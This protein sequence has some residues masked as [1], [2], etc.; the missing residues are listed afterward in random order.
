M[1]K[2]GQGYG[3]KR[4]RMTDRDRVVVYYDKDEKQT[5]A[6]AAVRQRLSLS[7]FVGQAALSAAE[8]EAVDRRTAIEELPA[9]SRFAALRRLYGIAKGLSP[10]GEWSKSLLADRKRHAKRSRERERWQGPE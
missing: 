4:S 3:G 7:A 10:H 6:E 5:V 1:A 9:G 8:K 2:K